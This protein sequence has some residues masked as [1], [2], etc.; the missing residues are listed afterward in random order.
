MKTIFL[1]NA[2]PLDF[3]DPEEE[4]EIET[5]QLKMTNDSQIDYKTD[6]SS[7]PSDQENKAIKKVWK[8]LIFRLL[9]YIIKKYHDSRTEQFESDMDF[10][11]NDD[12]YYNDNLPQ[13]LPGID[14]ISITSILKVVGSILA[15]LLFILFIIYYA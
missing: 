5:D 11:F 10:H 6:Q 14:T 9:L 7:V 8:P 3:N 12:K 13:V 1:N 2:G 4:V 15:L